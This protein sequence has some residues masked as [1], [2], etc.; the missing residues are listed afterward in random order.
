MRYLSPE[1]TRPPQLNDLLYFHLATTRPEVGILT[2]APVSTSSQRHGYHP[3]DNP[4]TTQLPPSTPDRLQ[5]KHNS[6]RYSPLSGLVI[7]VCTIWALV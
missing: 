1:S 6:I 4:T 5:T 2:I 7:T 3:D